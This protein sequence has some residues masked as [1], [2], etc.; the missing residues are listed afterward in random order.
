MFSILRLRCNKYGFVDVRPRRSKI[1]RLLE[2]FRACLTCKRIH[3]G[4]LVSGQVPRISTEQ[5]LVIFPRRFPG[6]VFHEKGLQGQIGVGIRVSS[7]ERK[8][9][10]VLLINRGP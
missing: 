3:T 7:F 4:S 6:H 2:D 10:V 9:A 8:A 1:G 5:L